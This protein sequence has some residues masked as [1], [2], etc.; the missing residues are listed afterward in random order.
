[1]NLE[2][3]PSCTPQASDELCGPVFVDHGEMAERKAGMNEMANANAVARITTI[4]YSYRRRRGGS[5]GDL[6]SG[7]WGSGESLMT[8]GV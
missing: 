3:T 7:R 1:M 5:G 6:R 4:R 2:A 8:G